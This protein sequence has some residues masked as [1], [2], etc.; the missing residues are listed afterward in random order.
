MRAHHYASGPPVS[1]RPPA[2]RPTAA[3]TNRDG[4]QLP[5]APDKTDIEAQCHTTRPTASRPTKR[6]RR[7]R[8]VHRVFDRIIDSPNQEFSGCSHR[9]FSVRPTLDA[10]GI[11][12]TVLWNAVEAYWASPPSREVDDRQP[13]HLASSRR[14]RSMPATM[15]SSWGCRTISGRAPAKLAVVADRRSGQVGAD[16]DL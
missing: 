3:G 8:L 1:R 16:G 9:T 11:R 2:C 12:S 10:A 6:H 14:A 13:P 7:R 4:R 15:T 5:I